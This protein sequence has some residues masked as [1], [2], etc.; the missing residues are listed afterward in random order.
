MEHDAAR[1]AEEKMHPSL[2]EH[3]AAEV[4]ISRLQI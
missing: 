2:R 1:A 4:V 3:E